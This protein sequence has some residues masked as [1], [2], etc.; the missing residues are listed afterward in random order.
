MNF[1]VL[2]ST[3]W[4]QLFHEKLPQRGRRLFRGPRRTAEL[5]CVGRSA[6]FDSGPLEDSFCPWPA[7]RT[8]VLRRF[9]RPLFLSPSY[10]P[11]RVVMLPTPSASRPSSPPA[12][13]ASTRPVAWMPTR[14]HPDSIKLAFQHFDVITPADPRAGA[15]PETGRRRDPAYWSHLGGR[16]PAVYQTQDHHAQ[17][18]SPLARA[19]P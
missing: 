9:L 16:D 7:H 5:V 11:F 10:P 14:L 15:W 19:R 8:S 6:A 2:L 12:P 17:W 1:S 18:V 3:T 4:S 13:L